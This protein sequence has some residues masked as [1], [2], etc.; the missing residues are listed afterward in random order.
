M[1]RRALDVPASA[2]I[3]AAVFPPPDR[4]RPCVLGRPVVG[5]PVF[6]RFL[7]PMLPVVGWFVR[8]LRDRSAVLGWLRKGGYVSHDT[9]KQKDLFGEL[10]TIEETAA[11]FSRDKGLIGVGR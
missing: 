10:P 7:F 8:S 6:P 4:L 3:S 11:R 2:W 1:R 5:K 9:E